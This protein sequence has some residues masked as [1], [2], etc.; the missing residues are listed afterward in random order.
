MKS[1]PRNDP[2][3]SGSPRL[4]IIFFLFVFL[5]S[6]L[7]LIF[8]SGNLCTNILSILAWTLVFSSFGI[9][10]YCKLWLKKRK[11]IILFIAFL[12]IGWILIEKRLFVRVINGSSFG[13]VDAQLLNED[14]AL[15]GFNFIL[16]QVQAFHASMV[17]F[18]KSA[19]LFCWP[20]RGR[21]VAA[22]LLYAIL[23]S[24]RAKI[25]RM[26]LSV[27]P[28][29]Y[30]S[31]A[32]YASAEISRKLAAYFR[33]E[34]MQA[35]LF[36]A[37]WGSALWLMKVPGVI[38]FSIIMGLATTIPY[39][40]MGIAALFPV[41]TTS[42]E[43]A[44]FQGVGLVIAFSAIW[45]IR[46]VIFADS[47]HESRPR[48][49]ALQGLVLMVAGVIIGGGIGF[50]LILPIYSFGFIIYQSLGKARKLIIIVPKYTKVAN[51]SS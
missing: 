6:I 47:L 51:L 49:S 43:A 9:P 13:R 27:I 32:A 42:V 28:N 18:S 33:P 21:L 30:F 2:Q 20:G 34:L 44:P 17:A 24:Q 15:E 46:Q 10:F 5:I 23:I 7:L 3:L 4:I 26:L 22:I 19:I 45:L 12:L 41:M 50:L 8:H 48:I 39:W 25:K 35:A 37:L 16:A 11:I 1:N 14:W 38:E 31:F 29:N 36:A 40:G